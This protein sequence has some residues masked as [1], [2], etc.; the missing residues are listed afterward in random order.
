MPTPDLPPATTAYIEPG[1]VDCIGGLEGVSVDDIWDA[2]TVS[3]QKCRAAM[4]L[5][6]RARLELLHAG[7]AADHPQCQR[8]DRAVMHVADVDK[9]YPAFTP[10]RTKD[11]IGG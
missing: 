11:I 10:T 5:L 4:Q 2:W 3:R 8:I 9:H 6:L 1:Q 7:L